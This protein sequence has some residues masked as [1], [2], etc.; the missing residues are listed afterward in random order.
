MKYL[1]MMFSLLK[2][3]GKRYT[4]DRGS[5]LAAALAYYTLFSLA[6]LMVIS[7]AVAEYFISD[8]NIQL[9]LITRIRI[10]AGIQVSEF[11]RELIQGFGQNSSGLVA[12]IISLGVMIFGA[13]N[14]FRQL[15]RALNTVWG[16]NFEDISDVA[17]FLQMNLLS[18]GL[19]LVTGLLLII[20]IAMNALAGIV[21]G[22]MAMFVPTAPRI[23]FLFEYAIPF[24]IV[25]FLFGL[26][27]RIVPDVLISWKDVWLGALLTATLTGLVLIGLRI[28]LV[29]SSFGAAYGAAGS[30]V[31]LLFIVYNAAQIFVFGA[32]F[33]QVYSYRYGSRSKTGASEEE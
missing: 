13:S 21:T 19:V 28:Y 17:H 26:L 32:V 22:L 1:R 15:K 29:V 4:A 10:V 7:I 33:T 12:T 14:V 24:I 5:M 27:Y 16:V 23:S 25:V 11:V 6:P 31:V 8:T 30:L 3:T 2:E 18:F 9:L 20:A